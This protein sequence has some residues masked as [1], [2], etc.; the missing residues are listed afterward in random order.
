[1]VKGGSGSLAGSGVQ[2]ILGILGGL[3]GVMTFP[4]LQKYATAT[5]VFNRSGPLSQ[6]VL[7]KGDPTAGGPAGC[8]PERLYNTAQGAAGALGG[9]GGGGSVGNPGNP[10]APNWGDVGFG[11]L[12]IDHNISPGQSVCQDAET[13]KIPD[14]GTGALPQLGQPATDIGG[15]DFTDV[16]LGGDGST[17]IK[18]PGTE[19]V[20][21]PGEPVPP[22]GGDGDGIEFDPGDPFGGIGVDPGDDTDIG[23]EGLGDGFQGIGDERGFETTPAGNGADIIALGLPSADKVAAQ[24][25]IN[26]IPNT[27]VVLNKGR[28]YFFRN[29]KDKQKAFPSIY[30]GG[31]NGSPIP[32]VD[33]ETGEMFA[34]LTTAS[35]FNFRTP[36]PPVSVI[37]GSQELGITTNQIEEYDFILGGFHIQNTGF[38]YEDPVIKII[39]RDTE[40]ENGQ[41]KATIVDG[42]IVELEIINNGTGFKR[43]PEVVIEQPNAKPGVQSGWGSKIYPIMNVIPKDEAKAEAD[44]IQTIFCPS[45]NQKNLV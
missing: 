35:L 11:G 32:V 38:L 2:K 31:Y 17:I 36:N 24:N 15:G 6:D 37:T 39:D 5:E 3:S 44:P 13:G 20:I 28:R 16:E 22:L 25:F 21:P 41:V 33:E 8:I 34:V 29:Q 23:I 45:K 30:I 10:G 27:T 12:P 43:I 14:G 42:R 4:V 7:T 18:G 40:E 9:G 19:I 26:G 1:M